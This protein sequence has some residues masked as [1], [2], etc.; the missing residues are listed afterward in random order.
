MGDIKKARK[1]YKTPTHPWNRVR[2]DLEKELTTEYGLQNKKEILRIESVLRDV[3]KQAK[4][5]IARRDPQSERE[6]NLLKARLT[7]LGLAPAELKVENVLDLSVKDVMERRLQTQVVRKGLARSML[8][9]RQLIIHGH[10]NVGQSKLAVPGH[11]VTVQEEGMI[12]YSAGS[13]FSDPNHPERVVA[14]QP[15]AV[16]EVKETKKKKKEEVLP[17]IPKDEAIEAME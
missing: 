10:I 14:K 17:D 1:K 8:Q 2:I 12:N 15:V 11:L 16:E 3:K 4:D 9:A 7:R 6:W 5:L 13:S